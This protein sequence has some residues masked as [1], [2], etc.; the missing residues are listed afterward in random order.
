MAERTEAP[1]MVGLGFIPRVGQGAGVPV[2]PVTL[3]QDWCESFPTFFLFFSLYATVMY[4]H[5]FCFLY[6]EQTAA[7]LYGAV[8]KKS[9]VNWERE[10]FALCLHSVV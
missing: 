4:F 7:V 10:T 1:G 8:L 5:I 3:G 6:L 9:C 2:C